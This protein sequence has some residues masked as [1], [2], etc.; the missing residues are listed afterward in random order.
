MI[1]DTKIAMSVCK[2]FVIKAVIHLIN[3][4]HTKKLRKV[5]GGNYMV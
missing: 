5:N 4:T 1:S 3:N 2:R